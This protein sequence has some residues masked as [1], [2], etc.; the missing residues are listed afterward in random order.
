MQA[1]VSAAGI[2]SFQGI[3]Q[4]H[5]ILLRVNTDKATRV[6]KGYLIS[7]TKQPDLGPT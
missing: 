7:T 2:V 1:S 3:C 4:H 5:T 6:V